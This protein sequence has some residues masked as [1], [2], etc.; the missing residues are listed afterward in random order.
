M[1]ATVSCQ[2]SLVTTAPVA[3]KMSTKAQCRL[4]KVESQS[5]LL[6]LANSRVVVASA[7]WVM[8]LDVVGA[9]SVALQH[10]NLV[11]K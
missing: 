9:P 3:R 8:L 10:L 4:V 1:I 2:E 7:T 5:K 11:T 6:R